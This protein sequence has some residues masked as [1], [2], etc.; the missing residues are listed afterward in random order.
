MADNNNDRAATLPKTPNPALKKLNHL[1]GDW[2]QAGAWEGTAS[3]EWMDGGFF[4]IQRFT[5]NTPDGHYEG[6]EYICF[7][8]DTQT[9]RSHL[10]DTNG[11]NFTYTYEINDDDPENV[12]ATIWF[13][14]KGSDNFLSGKMSKDG[15]TLTGRWQ[16]PEGDGKI[17]GYDAVLTR[18]NA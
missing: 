14:E 4:M 7:D 11:S 6:I 9:L 12:T 3:Y 8:E 15:N 17:G 18:V 10:M 16:W 2:K 13:G 5:G 1:L